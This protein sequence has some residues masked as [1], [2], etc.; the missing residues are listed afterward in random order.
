[1]YSDKEGDGTPIMQYP[2]GGN[3]YCSGDI[4]FDTVN[5]GNVFSFD[6][7]VFNTGSTDAGHED[8]DEKPDPSALD[9]INKWL[10]EHLGIDL[11]NP[12]FPYYSY[13]Y[14]LDG[15]GDGKIPVHTK[16]EGDV[17]CQGRLIIAPETQKS[18]INYKDEQWL[19]IASDLSDTKNT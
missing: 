16:I 14:N 2:Q 8:Q 12:R 11:V 5:V 4:I 13:A 7:G 19:G 18:Y 1:M 3:I 6:A 17:F 15:T 9:K 10:S